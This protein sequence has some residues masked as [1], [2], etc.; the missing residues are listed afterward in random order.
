ML[1]RIAAVGLILQAAA[2]PSWVKDV[3]AWRA[4]H[5]A[6]YSRDYVP[7]AGLAFLKEGINTAGSAPGNQVVLPRQVPASIGRFVYS[8]GRARFE[9]S[10]PTG[11]A[12]N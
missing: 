2:A 5:E 6:D 8:G 11:V 1:A 10:P 4:K 12:L 3:E 9:P 7:L